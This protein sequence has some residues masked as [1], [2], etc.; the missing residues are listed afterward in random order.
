MDP[1][2]VKGKLVHCRLGAWGADS[3]IKGLGGVGALIESDAFLDAA[4]IFMAPTTMVNSIAGKGINDYIHSTVYIRSSHFAYSVV[5][6]DI[7]PNL[8]KCF[9][10]ICRTPS[11]VIHK[12]EEIKISAPFVASF[13]SRGPNPGSLHLLKV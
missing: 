2:K 11:A 13:S 8:D 12:S 7:R 4:Q 1:T 3:V 10:D 6:I 9:F 5:F